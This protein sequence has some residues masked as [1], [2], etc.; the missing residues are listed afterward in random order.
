MVFVPLNLAPCYRPWRLAGIRHVLMAPDSVAAVNDILA[1]KK[2]LTSALN[3]PQGVPARTA[4]KV[5]ATASSFSGRGA[6]KVQ[7][8]I[9]SQVQSDENPQAQTE[10]FSQA[11]T[12]GKPQAQT[13]GKPQA[14][15][16]G[17][18]Q[19][20]TE[21]KPQVQTGGKPQAQTEKVVSSQAEEKSQTQGIHGAQ[22]VP[23]EMLNAQK[24]A[25]ADFAKWPLPWQE[26]LTASAKQPLIVWSYAALKEDFGG[27]GDA[28]RSELVRRL[29]AGM[30]L[31]KG[32][33]VLWPLQLASDPNPR[34]DIFCSALD[35]F[36]PRLLVLLY[37]QVPDGLGVTKL[38][39]YQLACPAA[40]SGLSVLLGPSMENLVAGKAPLEP[41]LEMVRSIIAPFAS[42]S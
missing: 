41:L 1:Q 34:P 42:A 17:K 26:R 27:N 33:H 31:R 29:Y 16:E 6:D 36:R 11:Q 5:V 30:A 14:Q 28:A 21:K 35:I 8:E 2:Q 20:Q 24:T 13:E 38:A 32:S 9:F 39:C 4:M 10:I 19:A 18:P 40:L 15:T 3:T 23:Q 25:K 12:E 37:D 7:S 22:G